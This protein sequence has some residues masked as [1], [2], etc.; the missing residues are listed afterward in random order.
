MKIR[1]KKIMWEGL[2]DFADN[3]APSA[4]VER[5]QIILSSMVECCMKSEG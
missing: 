3:L 1:G 2:C 4:V 5:Q